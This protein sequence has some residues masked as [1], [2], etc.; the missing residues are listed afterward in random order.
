ME[1]MP[2]PDSGSNLPNRAEQ[3]AQSQACPTAGTHG[4]AELRASW[5]AQT[6][7]RLWT[8]LN[9][10]R[11]ALDADLDERAEAAL[12]EVALFASQQSTVALEH[13]TLSARLALRRGD[14]PDAPSRALLEAVEE[15][16]HRDCAAEAWIVAAAVARAG[17]QP[18]QAQEAVREALRLTTPQSPTAGHALIEYS[19]LLHDSAQV[20][21]AADATQTVIQCFE[22]AG[23]SLA[24]GRA[25]L[26]MAETWWEQVLKTSPLPLRGWHE[27][28]APS[29]RP[30]AG[31][32]GSRSAAP[33]LAMAG[34]GQI[35]C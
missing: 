27:L 31:A 35:M 29:V 6:E 21:E 30:Q 3:G 18:E 15:E 26:Q 11:C 10:A 16:G 17:N 20:D 32:I 13:W 34:A 8:E 25:M 2:E 22:G 5:T 12:V 1:A 33:S 23:E 14:I 9:L 24:L 7:Q 28:T 4:R 19:R